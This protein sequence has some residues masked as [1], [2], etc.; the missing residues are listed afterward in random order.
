MPEI[1]HNNLYI[2]HLQALPK[3]AGNMIF[4]IVKENRKKINST[5]L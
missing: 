4:S 5:V 2:I 1:R 3:T